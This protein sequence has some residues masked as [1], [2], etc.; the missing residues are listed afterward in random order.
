MADK[1]IVVL[2]HGKCP[3]GFAAAYAAWKKFGDTAEY[4]PVDH[5]DP[6]PEGLENREVYIVDFCYEV[7]EQIDTLI[8]TTKR[9]VVLD[10]HRSSKMFVERVP[11][12][13][14]DEERSG[15][16]IAWSYF[17]PD[18]SV[19]RLMKYLEDGDLYRY[20][21][22]ET[23]N[24]FS[25]LLVL[26]FEF[27]AWDKLVL[28]LED[29]VKRAEILKKANAYT[30]FFGALA[31]SSVERAKKVRFEG[32][33]VYFVAT[34]PN[35]TM[36]SY[37]GHELYEKLPPFALIVTAH[38]NGFGVSIR[39]NPTMIDVSKIA[40]KYGGGGHPGSAGFFIPNGSTMP[41]AEIND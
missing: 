22:P 36:K 38:P 7:A 17:H 6:P 9:L 20:A 32:Y 25:Y 12:H 33:E 27:S 2:Y 24:I 11:E 30:E 13:V 31:Q 15:A 18:A 10:H 3:D 39:G 19:P 34:H 5:G 21:L 1:Q 4:L 28:G 41:W 37:V 35:I 26:S 23:R 16:T 40:A 14:Y 29:N 8:K